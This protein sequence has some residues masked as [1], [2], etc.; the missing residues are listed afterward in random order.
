MNEKFV[1]KKM[2]FR[3]SISKEFNASHYWI[4]S[5][6]IGDISLPVAYIF[7]CSPIKIGFAVFV[8]HTY[9]FEQKSINI[10]L[11]QISKRS[12]K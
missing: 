3:F 10:C 1:D 7:R 4:D 5:D 6:I 9:T 8:C 12:K 2:R 11:S